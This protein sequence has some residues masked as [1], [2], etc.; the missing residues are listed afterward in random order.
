MSNYTTGSAVKA[1]AR[2]TDFVDDA[3]SNAAI[4]SASRLIDGYCGRSFFAGIS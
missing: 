4:E 1:A 2:I 3:L